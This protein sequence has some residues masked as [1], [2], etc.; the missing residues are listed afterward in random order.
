MLQ[1]STRFFV[2]SVDKEDFYTD[3]FKGWRPIT[4]RLRT[5]AATKSMSIEK[6]AIA[7]P[8]SQAAKEA[9]EAL[10][11]EGHEIAS[12]PSPLE[13]DD[14]FG[15]EETE[16]KAPEKDKEETPEDPKQ[17]EDKGGEE[18]EKNKKT[19][20]EKTD[21]TPTMIPAWKIEI[22][23]KETAKQIRDLNA[24]IE[25]LSKKPAEIT[26]E[27]KE[28]LTD[29]YQALAEKH[30]ADPELLRAIENIMLK[31]VGVKPEAL[32]E[33]ETIKQERK[34]LE[35]EKAY[36]ADFDNTVVPAV[37][38]EYPDIS[39]EALA[40][41]KTKLKDYA[42]SEDYVKLPLV[43]IL[44]A[45]KENLITPP[46]PKKKTGESG[47]SGRTRT[48]QTVDFDKMDSDTFDSLTD[49]Q[50]MAFAKHQSK[51]GGA[52]WK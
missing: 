24:K 43:K 34:Q 35:Q 37:K 5:R 15:A 19:D 11:A 42:F 52:S 21:R 33:L 3:T 29:E 32:K 36:F 47:G 48:E 2:L 6:E 16:P 18:D 9:L 49:D 46:A 31:K 39:D 51:K 26:K 13:E 50:K 27:D 12:E 22:E 25:D 7:P 23:R 38:A 17:P 44:R 41:L 10:K 30:G 45:E 20:T 4:A 40:T 14:E 8:Q 28:E 1:K